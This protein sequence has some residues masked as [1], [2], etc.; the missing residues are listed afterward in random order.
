M[1]KKQF[2]FEEMP[3]AFLSD[4]K[5]GKEL[6]NLLIKNELKISACNIGDLE[7]TFF[8]KENI[9]TINKML[10]LNVYNKTNNQFLICNQSE[11]KL[12]IVMRYI[13]IEYSKNLL[14][15]I[16]EQVEELNN[17]TVNEITPHIISNA[18]QKIGYLKDIYT[19]PIGPPLPIST[20]FKI[21]NTLP[22]YKFA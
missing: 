20:N 14:F 10:I 7:K 9:N 17:L 12:I 4:N 6:R 1:Y 13:F 8:S 16:K 11:S 2:D 15:K 21:K 22:S 19:Q 5:K 18:E 3:I